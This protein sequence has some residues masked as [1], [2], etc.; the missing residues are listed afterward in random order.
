LLLKFGVRQEIRRTYLKDQTSPELLP[1]VN[2]FGSPALLDSRQSSGGRHAG[3]A[4][5]QIASGCFGGGWSGPRRSGVMSAKMKFSGGTGDRASRR[6]IA[7]C[8]ACVSA[9]ANGP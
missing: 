1:P 8:P 7:N 3:G 5:G 4:S 2:G 9:S 6:S